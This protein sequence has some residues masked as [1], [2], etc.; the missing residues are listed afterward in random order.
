M[1]DGLKRGGAGAQ[2]NVQNQTPASWRMAVEYAVGDG[3]RFLT[4]YASASGPQPT[5]N[6]AF[7]M[8]EDRLIYKC[9]SDESSAPTIVDLVPA[10][11][12]D[13]REA[14]DLFGW[15]F[16]DHEPMHP[17]VNHP[18]QSKD[19]TT[20]V[21]GDDAN[22]VSVGP[23]HASVIESGHFRFHVAGERV[24][25][26]DLQLF[27]KHRGL[28]IAAEGKP[29]G[30]GI[31]YVR[32][33]CGADSVANSVAYAD[34]CESL[35]GLAPRPG[36][37]RMRTVLLELERVYN[38]LNDISAIYAGVGFSPG[39]MLFAGL[40]ERAQRLNQLLTGH[41]FLFD[42]V[43]VASGGAGMAQGTAE[44]ARVSLREIQDEF[45]RIWS[46]VQ[47]AGSAQDRFEGVGV[48]SR[49]NALQLGAVGPTARAAGVAID[50]RAHSSNLD[51]GEFE[52]ALP[53]EAAGDVRSRFEMRGIELLQS[54]EI[55]ERLLPEP[56]APGATVQ[57]RDPSEIGVGVVESP[58]GRTVCIVEAQSGVIERLHLRTGSYANW[59]VLAHSA[60]GEL[61]ADFPLINKSFELCYACVDR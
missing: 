19:W 4:L 20:S 1:S 26:L 25:H 37:R 32:R 27:Y 11:V 42:T 30:E 35:L 40:K 46:G 56:H 52:V 36:L 28:E 61:I 31:E 55:L 15:E 22:Q 14:H 24:L 3:W 60:R 6:I 38:H 49:E 53:P 5:L 7:E 23:I 10:A 33:A 18:V 45:T 13:E 12:W 41:R 59:P 39:N 51:Y 58:R 48:V 43:Q 8:E 29:L 47:F 2:L 16:F 57:M 50:S 54:F 34:A 44:H 17:L 9:A 21:R